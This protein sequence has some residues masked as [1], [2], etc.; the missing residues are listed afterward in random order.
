MSSTTQ[1]VSGRAPARSQDGNAYKI[2]AATGNISG[3]DTGER[4]PCRGAS[5]CVLDLDITAFT[6]PDADEELDAI[7]QTSY[8]DG[9]SWVDLENF[10]TET[11]G[12][13]RRIFLLGIPNTVGSVVTPSDGALADNT[14][15]ELP[16]GTHMR[17]KMIHTD[18]LNADSVYAYNASMYFRG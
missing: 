11:A 5:I 17:L 4:V 1:S 13:Q 2:R 7:V 3:A 6:R 10:H 12:A 14:K 16:I 9:A 8:D 15:V 18:P